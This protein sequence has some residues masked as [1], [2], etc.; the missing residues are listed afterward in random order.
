MPGLRKKDSCALNEILNEI[1]K[2]YEIDTCKDV[3]GLTENDDSIRLI[4]SLATASLAEAGI[5]DPLAEA[6]YLL[7]HILK[8]GRSSL[9]IDS[10]RRLSRAE[11]EEFRTFIE[12]R[13]KRE[14]AQYITGVVDFRGHEVRVTTDTLIPRPETELVVDEALKFLQAEPRGAAGPV[15]IDL[16]TG[17]GCIAI[18]IAKEAAGSRVCATDISKAA[19]DIARE[20]AAINGVSSVV[21]FFHG[22]LFD[23]L[24]DSLK[25]KAD[26]VVSNPPYVS[27]PEM[28]ELAPEVKDFEPVTAL[29]GGPDG[30]DFIKRIIDEAPEY[31]KEGGL[32]IMEIGYSQAEKVLEIAENLGRYSGVAL[33]KDYSGIERIFTARLRPRDG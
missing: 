29:A 14:P 32:L 25:G 12:R 3:P 21:E 10:G 9:F 4:L 27:I 8:C 6:E 11:A 15:V 19:L 1:L 17:S 5:S 13:K 16:C 30:L 28:E 24:G 33:K 22:D 2:D 18:A 26:I 7:T 23:A 20:N 31:L